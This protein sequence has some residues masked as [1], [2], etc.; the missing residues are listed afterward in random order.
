ME[1]SVEAKPPFFFLDTKF[2]VNSAANNGV[3][4]SQGDVTGASCSLQLQRPQE[5]SPREPS[6][7]M[8]FLGKISSMMRKLHF[9]S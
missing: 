4:F 1:G 8:S 6:H 5:N 2:P 9:P 7:F 3:L